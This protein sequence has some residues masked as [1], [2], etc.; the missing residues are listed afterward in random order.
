MKWKKV[1]EHP[2]PDGDGEARYIIEYLN[3]SQD[4]R[5]YSI[6]YY[7]K[8]SGALRWCVFNPDEIESADEKQLSEL[9]LD[10]VLYKIPVFKKSIDDLKKEYP[11]YGDEKF[12]TGETPVGVPYSKPIPPESLPIDHHIHH[13]LE[14][15][16][17]PS[18]EEKF[19]WETARDIFINTIRIKVI[20]SDAAMR[21]A[22]Q[23]TDNIVISE[24]KRGRE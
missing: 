13:S 21:D 3:S 5:L 10:D 6:V 12:I 16:S 4:R 23:I 18:W 9:T 24:L 7:P 19:R 8:N 11:V 22:I 15:E 14:A 20:D 17:E 1:S 2:L